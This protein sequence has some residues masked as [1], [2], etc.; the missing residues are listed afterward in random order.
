MEILISGASTGIGKAC[1]IHM[2]RLGHSV[3]A[4]VRTSKN[5][6]DINKLD[7]RSLRPVYLDVTNDASVKEGVSTVIKSAGTLH[8]LINNAGVAIG[9]PIEAVSLE[10]WHR[11]FETNFFGVI[12]LTQCCLPWLRESKGRIINMS[13]LSGRL[14][15]PFMG[16]YAASKFALEALSDSLRREMR[17]HGVQVSVIE[18]SAIATPIWEKSKTEGLG[19]TAQYSA[20]M[21]AVYGKVMKHFAQRIDD[22]ARRAAPV[23]VVTKAVEHAL[24]ARRPRTR[25]PVGY[26]TKPTTLLLNV[27]PD[28]WVDRAF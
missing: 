26:R 16:P 17:P 5:F 23:T 13:S 4:G 14:A 12:R 8:A 19:K 10:D 21:T 2:A 27:L 7:V 11:Q 22:V 1:A 3:W 6:E 15:F 18:P 24:L 25:Y 9:G 20:D 28:A